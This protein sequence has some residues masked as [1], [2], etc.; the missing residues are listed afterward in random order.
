MALARQFMF[1]TDKAGDCAIA[2]LTMMFGSSDGTVVC[3]FREG[4]RAA[5][6]R[7]DNKGGGTAASVDIVAKAMAMRAL[8]EEGSTYKGFDR[9]GVHAEKGG[10]AALHHFE[11]GAVGVV[12]GENNA[13]GIFTGGEVR[14]VSKP[15]W[16]KEDFMA[17]TD[18]ISGKFTLEI[19]RG[20]DGAIGS[21]ADGNTA[22]YNMTETGDWDAPGARAEGGTED[23]IEDGDVFWGWGALK[24]VD[25]VFPEGVGRRPLAHK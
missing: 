19:L 17:I 12:E 7:A 11:T 14:G 15:A 22:D 8:G 13:G 21:T 1:M 24:G 16:G 4:V 20:G 25:K 9:P 5:T 23:G 6:K 10:G 18:G 2:G 3:M